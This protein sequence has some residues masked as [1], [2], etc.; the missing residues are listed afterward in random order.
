MLLKKLYLFYHFCNYT[1][2][3]FKED[4]IRSIVFFL[5]FMLSLTQQNLA[6][7][8]YLWCKPCTRLI[9]FN[10]KKQSMIFN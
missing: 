10:E 9:F 2:W 5:V 3:P 4:F 6:A 1:M 7:R 8:S